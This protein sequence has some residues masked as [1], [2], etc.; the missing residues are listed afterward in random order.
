MTT[1]AAALFLTT[2]AHGSPLSLPQLEGTTPI[3]VVISASDGSNVLIGGH[4]YSTEQAAAWLSLCKERFGGDDPVL[5]L[6]GTDTPIGTMEL[7]QK[8]VKKTHQR[9]WT[10]VKSS[11]GD[12]RVIQLVEASIDDQEILKQLNSQLDTT[13]K[14]RSHLPFLP[15]LM[16]P[17]PPPPTGAANIYKA[18]DILIAPPPE[19]IKELQDSK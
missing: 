10:I 14:T 16:V 13:P 6:G 18:T 19:L 2:G 1:L 8:L 4:R 7:W 12:F 11:S 3:F 5:I 9:I 15:A 17:P